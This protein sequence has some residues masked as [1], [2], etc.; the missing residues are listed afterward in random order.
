MNQPTTS[1]RSMCDLREK[2]TEELS[3]KKIH[4]INKTMHWRETKAYMTRVEVKTH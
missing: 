2:G 3:K 4:E 1:L